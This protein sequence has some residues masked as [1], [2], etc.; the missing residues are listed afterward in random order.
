MDEI[1]VPTEY[2]KQSIPSYVTKPI[3]IVP[4]CTDI[5]KFDKKYTKPV[6]PEIEGTF[7]FYYVGE[8]SKRKN[9]SDIVR[10]FHCEFKRH[11]PV[12]LILKTSIPGLN[13]DESAKA[14]AE[15]CNR[16]K[17]ETRLYPNVENYKPEVIITNRLSEE[18]LFGL[19]TYCH[20]FVSTSRAEAW[21]MGLSDAVGFNNQ[22]VFYDSNKVSMYPYLRGQSSGRIPLDSEP[23]F[24]YTSS[25][26]SFIGSSRESWL[27]SDI[28]SLQHQ[29]RL[30]YE[31][32][33]SVRPRNRNVDDYSY[34]KVGQIMKG[35]LS[36]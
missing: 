15:D 18:Q 23:C 31:N 12:S 27:K 9:I 28:T 6:I 21:H 1:F 30:A 7:R 24:G 19:H 26:F 34:E 14:I 32:R 17:T 11:E 33:N 3:R 4:H 8:C 13:P 20:C 25:P 36:E 5:T 10:A 29:M 2:V 35:L 16:I 22:V